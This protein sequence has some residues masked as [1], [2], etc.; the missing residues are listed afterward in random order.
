MSRELKTLPLAEVMQTGLVVLQSYDQISRAVS[1]LDN[2]KFRHLPVLDDHNKLVGIIS[3]TDIDK[4]SWGR[5]L[6]KNNSKSELN[7]SLYESLLVKD[8]M[9]K[10][11]HFLYADQ[12][13]SKAIELFYEG[14]FR[15]IPIVEDG[16]VVGIVTPQDIL[17]KLL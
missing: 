10:N 5:S 13:V 14:Q 2:E 9:T 4:L 16:A 6:F 8:V 1:I 17:N 11:V 3:Q 12:S 15:A 7:T